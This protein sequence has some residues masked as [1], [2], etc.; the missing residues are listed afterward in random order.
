M[1]VAFAF[2]QGRRRTSCAFYGPSTGHVKTSR[3][4]RLPTTNAITLVVA[5]GLVVEVG[6]GRSRMARGATEG[7]QAPVAKASTETRMR[8]AGLLVV[9]KALGEDLVA[10]VRDVGQDVGLCDV[11]PTR[12]GL[13]G[14]HAFNAM[15]QVVSI[16]DE[17]AMRQAVEGRH[18]MQTGETRV[19]VSRLLPCVRL[20]LLPTRVFT[21]S[22]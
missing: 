5:F 11:V 15:V 13:M 9:S 6:Q 21:V 1:S 4:R 2:G 16:A 12:D 18:A 17:I 10:K 3:R 20:C 7:R 8:Q 19:Q 22:L 14:R